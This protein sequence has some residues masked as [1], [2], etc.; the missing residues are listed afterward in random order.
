MIVVTGRSERHDQFTIFD[1]R[2]EPS[3][4]SIRLVYRWDRIRISAEFCLST[5]RIWTIQWEDEY[6]TR[7]SRTVGIK[8]A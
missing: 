6:N 7:S 5:L 2:L 3:L 1:R 4:S 8:L